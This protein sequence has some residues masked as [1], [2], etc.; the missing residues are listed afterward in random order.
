MLAF[1]FNQKTGIEIYGE[2]TCDVSPDYS[3]EYYTSSFGQGISV[4]AMQMMQAYSAFANGGNMVKPHL[5]SEMRDGETNETIY[6]ND[7]N[8]V[9]QPIS[10]EAAAKALE[11]MYETTHYEGNG[12]LGTGVRYQK[13]IDL[14][15]AGKT[16]QAQIA[17]K[18]E[19]TS[20]GQNYIYSFISLAPADDPEII[21]YTVIQNP[22]ISPYD[23]IEGMQIPVI[24]N[25]IN[26]LSLEEKSYQEV[27]IKVP[28]QTDKNINAAKE[29]LNSE[30]FSNVVIVGEGPVTNQFPKI[31]SKENELIVLIGTDNYKMP[32][33]NG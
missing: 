32:N 21:V 12:F 11:L 5:I 23:A 10:A 26:Y 33:V 27:K 6:K 15:I 30:G 8:Y 3:S 28:Y 2:S 18:G 7:A 13:M 29:S 25:T 14:P 31:I 20:I 24:N 4:N 19:Y 22:Q 17:S 9:G 1:G 16:G